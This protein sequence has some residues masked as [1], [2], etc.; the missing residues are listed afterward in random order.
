M[1]PVAVPAVVPMCDDVPPISAAATL[2]RDAPIYVANEMPVDEV[3]AWAAAQPGFED[4]WI[5]REHLGW[6]TLAFSRDADLRQLELRQ[7]F[8]DVGAVVVAVP[9]TMADLEHLQAK[10][11][12]RLPFVSGSGIQSQRGVVTIFVGPLLPERV[13]AVQS[14]GRAGRPPPTVEA[15]GFIEPGYAWHFHVRV[16]CGVEWLGPLNS[17]WW[18]TD[19]AAGRNLPAAWAHVVDGGVLDLEVVMAEGTPPTLRATANGFSLVYAAAAGKPPA[20]A[21]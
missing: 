19:G 7:R 3:R 16:P 11:H 5:D 17:V 14:D 18:R 9:W 20:C 15:G 1:P 13:A 21:Q 4:I 10:V 12:Q 6:I 8:P 2:Y